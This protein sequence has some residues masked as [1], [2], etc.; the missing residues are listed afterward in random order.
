MQIEVTLAELN[1]VVESLNNL[2]KVPMP[3]KYAFR[4]GRIAKAFQKE[5]I[6]LKEHRNEIYRKYGTEKEDGTIEV[7]KSKL[8]EFYE[9]VEGL[10]SEIIKV[11][12]DPMPLSL[13]ENSNVTIADMAW[14]ENFFIDDLLKEGEI[15]KCCEKK[16][17]CTCGDNESCSDCPNKEEAVAV[18]G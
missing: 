7:D 11:D 12:F 6:E 17:A 18:G 8:K 5:L 1:N 15:E 13:L 14:L 16:A 10:L 2:V 4:F 9:E 3:A